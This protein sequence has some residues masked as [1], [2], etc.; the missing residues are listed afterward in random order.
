MKWENGYFSSGYACEDC[1][2][3]VYYCV[4]ENGL[5]QDITKSRGV[6]RMWVNTVVCEGCAENRGLNLAE[7]FP[8]GE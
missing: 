3:V 5:S 4:I 2:E 6:K 7:L 1:D 8:Q